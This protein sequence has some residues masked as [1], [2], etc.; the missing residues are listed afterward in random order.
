MSTEQN[1]VGAEDKSVARQITH[2]KAYAK[3]NGWIGASRGAPSRLLTL[4]RGRSGCDLLTRAE[5]T[6]CRPFV[7]SWRE[8]Y[9]GPFSAVGSHSRT[10]WSPLALTTIA[11]SGLNAADQ[12]ASP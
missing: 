5:R 11:P 9:Q 2:A 4:A 7:R 10:V 12:T 8:R 1:G 6:V 3:Q